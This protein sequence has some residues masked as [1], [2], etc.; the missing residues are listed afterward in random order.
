MGDSMDS[1]YVILRQMATMAIYCLIGLLLHKKNLVSKEGCRALSKVLLYVIFPCVIISSF[2]READPETTKVLLLCIVAS[3]LLLALSMLVSTLIFRKDPVS[4]FSASFSNAG[5]MGIPLITMAYGSEP[6]FYIAPFVAL[7]NILQWTYGQNLLLGKRNLR[8]K[9]ILLN[10]L[11]LS[12]AA[13][14]LLYALPVTLPDLLTKPI[15]T[16]AACNAPIAMIILG[17]YLAEIPFK[18]FL[19]TKMAWLV[20]LLRLLL[21]PALSALVLV[22]MPGIAPSVK[23]AL[24]I[25]AS[26]P[27]GIN[28]AIYAELLGK[29]YQK[30]VTLICN[31]T[32][33]CLVTLPLMILLGSKLIG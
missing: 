7:L 8:P 27:V 9:E 10:P 13:G 1:V 23:I 16:L 17:F 24:L 29:D 11:V 31:S 22:V 3:V 28:V 4:S 32:V 2:L 15:S 21:I 26:A 6:V 30:A 33:L 25:A 19:C 14:L 5:F 18:Q 20:S 12:F